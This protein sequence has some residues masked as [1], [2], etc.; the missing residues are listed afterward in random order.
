MEVF[1]D[2]ALYYNAFYQDKNYMAEARQV[3][4]LLKKYGNGA[5]QI[6]NFGCGTGKHDIELSKMGYCCKGIDI[7]NMRYFFK[8]ELEFYLRESGFELIDN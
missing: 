6:I 7:H 4:I 8:P 1:Q 5:G 2:Y 3:D